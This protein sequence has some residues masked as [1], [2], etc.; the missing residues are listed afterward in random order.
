MDTQ[1]FTLD[2]LREAA[3][4]TMRLSCE[5]RDFE[6]R[7]LAA[8]PEAKTCHRAPDAPCAVCNGRGEVGG[9]LATG[10]AQTDPCPACA[11]APAASPTIEKL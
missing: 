2:Q 7:L 3:G 10:D 4:E 6:K 5:W 9:P 11:P 8:K 1:V